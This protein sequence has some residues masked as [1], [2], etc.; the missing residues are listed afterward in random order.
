MCRFLYS[1]PERPQ[2]IDSLSQYSIASCFLLRR[3]SDPPFFS[4][5]RISFGLGN[6]RVLLEGSGKIG[7]DGWMD[8]ECGTGCAEGMMGYI[9]GS[10][11]KSDFMKLVIYEKIVPLFISLKGKMTSNFQILLF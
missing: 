11:F 6:R 8:R 10:K 2:V 4:I 7:V 9:N 3:Y 5:L 1:P